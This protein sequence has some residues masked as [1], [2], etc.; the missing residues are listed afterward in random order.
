ML[1]KC[2]PKYTFVDVSEACDEKYGIYSKTWC[3]A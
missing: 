1:I 2:E 3:D